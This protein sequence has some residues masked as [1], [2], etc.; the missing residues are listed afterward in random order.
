MIFI[1]LRNILELKNIFLLYFYLSC[2]APYLTENKIIN[3]V[4]IIIIIILFKE[5]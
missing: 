2:G 3:W 1:I 4:F 5:M